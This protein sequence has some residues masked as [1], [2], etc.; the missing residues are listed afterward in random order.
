MEL[1][2]LTMSDLQLKSPSELT[3]N[4]LDLLFTAMANINF[5]SLF[6]YFVVESFESKYQ[7]RKSIPAAIF[8]LSND[9]VL[10]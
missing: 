3:E 8:L 5:T 4:E 9:K 10:R 2:S 6:D 7:I 1:P